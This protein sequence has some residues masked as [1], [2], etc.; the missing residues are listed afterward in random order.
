MNTLNKELKLLEKR[1]KLFVIFETCE[2]ILSNFEDSCK[3][4]STINEVLRNCSNS[5]PVTAHVRRTLYNFF[6]VYKQYLF[7]DITRMKLYY[8][9]DKQHFFDYVNAIKTKTQANLLYY[10]KSL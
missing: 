5:Y 1:L 7:E 8:Q 10:G 2:F 6:E 9:F 4:A 3:D